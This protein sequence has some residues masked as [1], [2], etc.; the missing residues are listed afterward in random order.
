MYDATSDL[1]LLGTIVTALLLV[2]WGSGPRPKPYVR[3]HMV[4]QARRPRK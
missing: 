4:D 2:I 3:Y 1:L